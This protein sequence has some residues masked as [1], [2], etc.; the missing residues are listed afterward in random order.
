M[1]KKFEIKKFL[2]ATNVLIAIVV[3]MY[4]L[5]C[6][7][8]LPQGYNGYKPWIDDLPPAANYL[9]GSSGG[10]VTN[11]LGY[12]AGVVNGTAFYRRFTQMFLHGGLLHLIAN[13]IGFIFIGRYAE[14][15]FGWWITLIIFATVG[16]LETFITDPLYLAIAPSKVEEVATAVSVGASGGIYGLMGASLAAI[17]FD[18]K[19]FKNISRNTLLVS[20]AYGIL[21]TYVVSFGWTTV[22]HNVALVLGLALGTL[23]I[24]PF[25]LMKNN[26]FAEH[27]NQVDEP[28][29]DER[30]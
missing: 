15:R 30:T 9:L 13:I 14:K 23:I 25:F 17:F 3:I 8:P 29:T 7:L 16:V 20:A 1:N 18:I 24:L 19:S 26:I 27:D 11:Y 22:C 21:T 28:V 12:G 4:L 2:T 5:D 6:Y 10:L